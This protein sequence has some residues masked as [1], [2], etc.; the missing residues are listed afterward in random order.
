MTVQSDGKYH[1]PLQAYCERQVPFTIFRQTAQ[2]E[3]RQQYNMDIDVV[4]NKS[5]GQ[6]VYLVGLL[7]QPGAYTMSGPT[8]AL[9]ALKQ[10]T[11][12]AMMQNLGGSFWS[13]AKATPCFADLLTSQQPLRAKGLTGF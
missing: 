1:C 5:S 4:L 2:N 9:Q 10:R 13:G 7:N 3:Y 6:Q 12:S 8:T 11:A